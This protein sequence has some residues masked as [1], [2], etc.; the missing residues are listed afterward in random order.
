MVATPEGPLATRLPS[1]SSTLPPQLEW[2][3]PNTTSISGSVRAAM[4][5]ISLVPGPTSARSHF[6][7]GW[8]EEARPLKKR[9]RAE[10]GPGTRLVVVPWELAWK[11]VLYCIVLYY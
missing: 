11:I 5:S 1:L 8:G 6:F 4:L 10:V 2:N 3:C 7:S 9:L